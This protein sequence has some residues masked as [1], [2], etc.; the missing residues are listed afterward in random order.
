MY[1]GFI[2]LSALFIVL[3]ILIGLAA[4]INSNFEIKNIIS[5]PA[6]S[7]KAQE[8][9]DETAPSAP[10]ELKVIGNLAEA[11]SGGS[12]DDLAWSPST[13]DAGVA[14][15]LIFQIISGNVY[16]PDPI[17]EV[18]TTSY[19]RQ[20]QTD[21]YASDYSY[22]VVAKDAA[23]NLSGQSNIAHMM[24]IWGD[25]LDAANSRYVRGTKIQ[26]VGNG[27]T[28]NSTA[29]YAGAYLMS[30]PAGDYEVTYSASGYMPQ[31][32]TISVSDNAMSTRNV[33]LKKLKK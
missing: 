14:S 17:A 24:G 13:D 28:Y 15:Y 29:N 27:N 4:T 16:D 11:R 7:T 19:S 22:Y 30:L 18:T 10:Q 12:R 8:L 5:N 25:V 33:F 20:F 31:K 9:A 2:N 26:A 1:K 32:Y 3:L 6:K 21:G 23:G